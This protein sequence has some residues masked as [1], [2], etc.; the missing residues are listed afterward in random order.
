MPIRVA[1]S[2][3]RAS[4]TKGSA[5]AD[6]YDRTTISRNQGLGGAQLG[7][8]NPSSLKR[9]RRMPLHFAAARSA[10][11]S[12]I[13]RALARK[14]LARAANDVCRPSAPM[15]KVTCRPRAGGSKSVARSTAGWRASASA[16]SGSTIRRST[17]RRA[18]RPYAVRWPRNRPAVLR[19]SWTQMPGKPHTI[20]IAK[21]LQT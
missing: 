20:A 1:G 21:H 13:A 14:A 18:P 5:R 4:P 3:S 10:A 11:H 6:L 9:S 2:R 15:T 17:D 8:P 12:P 16:R 19:A 7:R